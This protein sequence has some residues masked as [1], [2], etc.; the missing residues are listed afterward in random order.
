MTFEIPSFP[1]YQ[2]ANF[3][4]FFLTFLKGKNIVFVKKIDIETL[5]NLYFLRSQDSES[6]FFYVFLFCLFIYLAKN[7]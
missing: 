5:T 1:K 7:F 6:V 4:T 2:F 3:W